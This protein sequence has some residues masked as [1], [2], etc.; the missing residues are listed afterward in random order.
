MEKWQQQGYGSF[1]T[2][3]KAT[4]K[5]RRDAKKASAAAAREAVADPAITRAAEGL[6]ADAGSRHDKRPGAERKSD[7]FD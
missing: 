6:G 4:D 5:A 3:S 7:N 1:H 2:W